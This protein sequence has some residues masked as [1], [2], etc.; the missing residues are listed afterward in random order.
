MKTINEIKEKIDKEVYDFEVAL[1][2]LTMSLEDY[3]SVAYKDKDI[4]EEDTLVKLYRSLAP[5]AND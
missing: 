4:D 3:I 5:L 1:S 2:K